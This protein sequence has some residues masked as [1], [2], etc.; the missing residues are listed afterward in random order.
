MV[1]LRL[2]TPAD[3][4]AIDAIYDPY[5]LSSTCT[6]QHEPDPP[7]TRAAKLAARAPA[8]PFVVAEEGGSM[9]GFGSLSSFR[10]R[11]GY[12]HTVENSVYVRQGLHRSGVGTVIMEDLLARARALGHR[13]IVAGISADQEASIRFHARFGFVET[14]RLARV[15]NKFERWLDLVFMQKEI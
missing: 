1:T 15:G 14:G 5:V 10:D 13:V 3:A 2:A 11:W 6:W 7:G 8:H 4:D 12:R 9:V